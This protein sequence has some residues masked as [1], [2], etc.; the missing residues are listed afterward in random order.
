[1]CEQI[2][3]PKQTQKHTDLQRSG[4]EQELQVGQ[5]ELPPRS[6]RGNNNEGIK[7]SQHMKN[8]NISIVHVGLS[9]ERNGLIPGID[10]LGGP[11]RSGESPP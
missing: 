8:N 1:M 2:K 10:L 4:N 11:G 3:D 7:Y 6:G 5:E 9:K